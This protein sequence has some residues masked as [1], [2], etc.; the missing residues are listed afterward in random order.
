MDHL[1][2]ENELVASLLNYSDQIQDCVDIIGTR[3]VFSPKN[4]KIYEAI[5]DFWSKGEKI[6]PVSISSKVDQKWIFDLLSIGSPVAATTYARILVEKSLRQEIREFG[7]ILSHRAD[8]DDPFELLDEGQTKLNTIE[9][10]LIRKSF[11]TAKE[12]VSS[13]LL[14]ATHGFQG[15]PTG[16]RALQDMLGGW[17]NSNLIIVAGRPSSGKTALGLGSAVR[18]AKTGVPVGVFSLEMSEAELMIRALGSAAKVDTFKLSRGLIDDEEYKKV[19]RAAEELS[20]IPLY[21]DDSSGISHA[22]IKAKIRKLVR[23]KGVK[24][25][26][27]DYLQL[28]SGDKDGNRE[29]EVSSISRAFKAT[30]KELSIPI[31]CLCQLSRQ[32]ETRANK[33]PIL[34]DLRES[35]AIEQDA[36]IV[37]FVHGEIGS[38]E[39]EIITA[40]HRNGP[41]DEKKMAFVKEF[42]SFEDIYN[43]SH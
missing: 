20:K 19:E 9:S 7:R 39:R 23:E 24:L 16:Y 28:V 29:Q 32:P 40:K 26:V 8:K 3:K 22:N 34:S 10:G 33:K 25:I 35:G 15:T 21:I 41:T 42:A 37:I 6:D 43:N 13:A 38:G 4:Q 30:A 2:I 17:R 1:N 14:S 27:V 12:S 5:I 11:S 31:V 36:D 18:V